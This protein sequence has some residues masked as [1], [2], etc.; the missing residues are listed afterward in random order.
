MSMLHTHMQETPYCTLLPFLSSRL[1]EYSTLPRTATHCNTMQHTAT[2]SRGTY[3]YSSSF[4]VFVP[5]WEGVACVCICGGGQSEGIQSDGTRIQEAT[6]CVNTQ[7][8]TFS[9]SLT[10]AHTHAHAHTYTRTHIHTHT[11]DV[12]QQRH[13]KINGGYTDI[14]HVC[15]H[16]CMYVYVYVCLFVRIYVRSTVCVFIYIFIYT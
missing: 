2:H 6:I 15:I 4:V 14:T 8:N 9:L 3:L 16:G 11:H 7:T 1:C 12:S 5:V 10:H 13:L